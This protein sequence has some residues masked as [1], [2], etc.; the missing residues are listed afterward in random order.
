MRSMKVQGESIAQLVNQFQTKHRSTAAVVK[1]V[2]VKETN[3][4]SMRREIETYLDV[5]DSPKFLDS[6]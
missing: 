2:S 4:A 6:G 5:Y 3:L 1:A